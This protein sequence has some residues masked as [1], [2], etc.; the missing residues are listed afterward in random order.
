[1]D[2]WPIAKSGSYRKWLLSEGVRKQSPKI[3]NIAFYVRETRKGYPRVRF[4]RFGESR[5]K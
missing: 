2:K 5:A 4:V 3:S 1:M